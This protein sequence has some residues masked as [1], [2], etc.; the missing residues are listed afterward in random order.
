M[1]I[2]GTC[3]IRFQASCGF[4]RFYRKEQVYF[5]ISTRSKNR[6][7]PRGRISTQVNGVFDNK[8]YQVDRC[9]ILHYYQTKLLKQLYERQ[10]YER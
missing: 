6:G 10:I 4:E 1:I 2:I 9:M 8:G 7:S 3:D 5:P